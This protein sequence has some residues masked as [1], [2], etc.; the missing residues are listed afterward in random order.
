M[1]AKI[2]SGFPVTR[3]ISRTEEN[4]RISNRGPIGWA[5]LIFVMKQHWTGCATV[6]KT[7]WAKIVCL[8]IDAD[9]YMIRLITF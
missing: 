1:T 9:E 2:Y 6:P 3:Q 8:H 4:A 5:D 7:L